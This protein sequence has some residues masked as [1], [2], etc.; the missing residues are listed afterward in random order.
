MTRVVVVLFPV[1]LF[2]VFEYSCSFFLS[3]SHGLEIPDTGHRPNTHGKRMSDKESAARPRRQV[4]RSAGRHSA[5]CTGCSSGKRRKR[6]IL[7]LEP[8]RSYPKVYFVFI[9]CLLLRSTFTLYFLLLQDRKQS[10]HRRKQSAFLHDAIRG[11][12]PD[13]ESTAKACPSKRGRTRLSQ[14]DGG[15]TAAG[16]AQGNPLV[17]RSKRPRQTCT[18]VVMNGQKDDLADDQREWRNNLGDG[19]G[20]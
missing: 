3:P 20:N 10:K 2:L 16:T 17:A 12:V 5:R 15:D 11:I 6:V 1:V 19:G 13:M 18:E 8:K 9:L 7:E 4:K 14:L